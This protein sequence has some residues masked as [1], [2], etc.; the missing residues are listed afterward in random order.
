MRAAALAAVLIAGSLAVSLPTEIQGQS[1]K[2]SIEQ[3]LQFQYPPTKLAADKLR[4]AQPGTVL[5]VQMNGMAASPLDEFAFANTYKDGRI[6]RSAASALIH[7]ARRLRELL[8]GDRVYLLKTE[9]KDAGIVFS[10]QS[11][12]ACDG[13]QVD[14]MQMAYRASLTFQ[15]PKGY[16]ETADFARIQRTIGEVFALA[17]APNANTQPNPAPVVSGGAQSVQQAPPAPRPEPVRIG[18]GQT[19]E[20]VVAS[21]GQPGK[22]ID[23]GNK[24]IYVYSD[25]KVTFVDGKV[26]DVQ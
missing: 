12:I 11:C 8:A 7:D 21:L 9:V 22:V 3:Q 23:L 6:R 26:S 13:S 25:L 20:Q 1:L 14:L 5:V 24:K 10:V 15:F 19:T 16:L 4:I 2:P 17:G 18:L